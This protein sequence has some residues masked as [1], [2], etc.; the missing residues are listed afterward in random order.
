LFF[1]MSNLLCFYK[2]MTYLGYHRVIT[3]LLF[4]RY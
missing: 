1:G 2:I 4:F 3:L